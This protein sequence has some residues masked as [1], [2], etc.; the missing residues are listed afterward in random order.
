MSIKVALASSVLCCGLLLGI[1]A[2]ASDN[3]FLPKAGSGFLVLAEGK[4]GG[5]D[6]DAKPNEDKCDGD[7]K[8]GEGKCGDA[9]MQDLDGDADAKCGNSSQGQ[10]DE[11]AGS[12]SKC[13]GAN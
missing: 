2:Q 9:M 13:G 7:M 12:G 10:S 8:C 4:C 3:P 1:Q 6:A 5:A 11:G